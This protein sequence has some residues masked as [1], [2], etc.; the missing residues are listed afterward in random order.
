M[1]I[2]AI[3]QVKM[4]PVE[5]KNCSPVLGYMCTDTCNV[6]FDIIKWG[7]KKITVGSNKIENTGSWNKR[8]LLKRFS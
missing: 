7:L 2:W 5:P 3:Y 8:K 1:Y 4:S 6:S